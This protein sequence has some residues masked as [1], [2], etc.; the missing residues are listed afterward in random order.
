MK[1]MIKSVLRVN[2]DNSKAILI[3]SQEP[4]ELP[5]MYAQRLVPIINKEKKSS[6]DSMDV[7]K[8]QELKDKFDGNQRQRPG[9]IKKF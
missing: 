6:I 1:F 4:G 7:K 9:T 2:A 3:P 5:L 8:Q